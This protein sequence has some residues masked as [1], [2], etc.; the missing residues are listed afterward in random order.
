MLILQSKYP[1]RHAWLRQ[2]IDSLL[3]GSLY[4][5]LLVITAANILQN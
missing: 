4:Q 2:P 1:L 5:R 3:T